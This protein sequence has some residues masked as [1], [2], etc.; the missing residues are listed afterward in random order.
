MLFLV[1]LTVLRTTFPRM[2]LCIWLQVRVNEQEVDT[3]GGKEAAAIMLSFM[4]RG[5]RR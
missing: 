3:G 2:L 4:I 1:N 5:S